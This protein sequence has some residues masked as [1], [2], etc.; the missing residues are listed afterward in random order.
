V[1]APGGPA[2]PANPLHQRLE[3]IASRPVVHLGERARVHDAARLMALHRVSCVPVTDSQGQVLGMV[4][5]ARLLAVLRGSLDGDTPVLEATE[6]ML[7][8]DS[9]LRCDHGWQLCVQR[10]ATHL[11]VLDAAQRLVGVVSEGDFRRL[12]QLT[13]LAG[14]RLVPSVM[15]PVARMV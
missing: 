10:G 11:A 6:P 13:V 1:N 7:C 2:T 15:Q 4:T 3:S 9:S 8:V 12:N 14:R 5:E